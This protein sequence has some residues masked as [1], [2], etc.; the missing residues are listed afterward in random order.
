LAARLNLLNKL[1]TDP[2]CA[3]FQKKLAPLFL[4]CNPLPKFKLTR[5]G[6]FTLAGLNNPATMTLAPPGTPLYET[7]YGNVAPRIGVAYHLHGLRNCD[8]ILRAGF[9]IFYDLGQGS[10]GA[11]SSFFPYLNVKTVAS[12]PFPLSPSERS[13]SGLYCQ[14][15]RQH[16]CCG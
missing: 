6:S 1:H 8:A 15:T 12:A 4:G 16:Y 13:S 3:A 7:T 14:S 9:G 5:L 2:R 11:V 10:L